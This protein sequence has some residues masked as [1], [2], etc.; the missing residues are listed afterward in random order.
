LC[1][2]IIYAFA[3]LEKFK[4]AAFEWNDEDTEWS[5]GMYQNTVDLKLK[6]PSLKVMIAV[7]G[8]LVVFLR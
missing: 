8:Y 2:H 6:N 1:T 4:L 5:K 7:G 3:K